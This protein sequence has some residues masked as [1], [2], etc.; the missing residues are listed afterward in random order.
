[1]IETGRLHG[2]E[3]TF[4]SLTIR[5]DER[6]DTFEVIKVCQ[7]CKQNVT[8]NSMHG[9]QTFRLGLHIDGNRIVNVTKCQYCGNLVEFTNKE[10]KVLDLPITEFRSWFKSR[11]KTPKW[12]GTWS[13]AGLLREDG[14]SP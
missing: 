8:L 10:A 9:R 5:H 4:E 6:D 7:H 3:I 2:K 11:L 12:D 14:T 1:M 13:K